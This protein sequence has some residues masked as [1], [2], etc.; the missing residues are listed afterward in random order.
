[1]RIFTL[2]A[3]ALRVLGSA[4]FSPGLEDELELP[5]RALISPSSVDTDSPAARLLRFSSIT[6]VLLKSRLPSM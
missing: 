2:R 1:M 3:P 5:I 4:P 6:T